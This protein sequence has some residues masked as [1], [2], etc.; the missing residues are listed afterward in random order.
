[1]ATSA[2]IMMSLLNNSTMSNMF[3]ITAQEKN[4][5][6]QI[7][8]QQCENMRYQMKDCRAS[9]Y[10]NIQKT[11]N[12]KSNSRHYSYFNYNIVKEYKR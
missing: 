8:K 11:Y 10:N 2:L 7:K 3:D 1:M 12:P 9:M 6:Q 4:K 5:L